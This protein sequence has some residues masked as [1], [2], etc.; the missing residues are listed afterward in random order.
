MNALRVPLCDRVGNRA[1]MVKAVQAWNLEGWFAMTFCLKAHRRGYVAMGSQ[2]FIGEMSP[3]P[4]QIIRRARRTTLRII[5]W[6]STTDRLSS[7]WNAIAWAGF[8]L[9]TLHPL[10]PPC[11]AWALRRYGCI[12]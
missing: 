2:R 3:V 9:T 1:C 8:P 12:S 11:A 6:Q 4:G 5:G 7:A 10:R